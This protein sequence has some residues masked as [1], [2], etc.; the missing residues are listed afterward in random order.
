MDATEYNR[1]N[2]KIKLRAKIEKRETNKLVIRE[3]PFSTTTESVI[4]SIEEAVRK[5]RIKIRS[6]SDFTA[7]QVEI[8]LTLS[9]GED[10]GKGHFLALPFHPMR[11]DDSLQYRGDQ[12]GAPG[13]DGCRR[14]HPI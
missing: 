6:I 3:I 11:G 7:A 5:R 12:R 13:A 8:L 4:A 9:P 2:G 10:P 14:S 1:G